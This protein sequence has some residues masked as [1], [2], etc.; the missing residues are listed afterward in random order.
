[1]AGSTITVSYYHNCWFNDVLC[2]QTLSLK[3][4]VNKDRDL[5]FENFMLKLPLTL[6]VKLGKWEMVLY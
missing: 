3:N 6:Y 5:K 1:M 4:G 2:E